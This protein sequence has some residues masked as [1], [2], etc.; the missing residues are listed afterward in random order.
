MKQV[1]RPGV[2]VLVMTVLRTPPLTRAQSAVLAVALGATGVL[3]VGV[4]AVQGG[5]EARPVRAAAA[6]PVLPLA[7]ATVGAA[8]TPDLPLARAPRWS[9]VPDVPVAAATPAAAVAPAPAVAATARTRPVLAAAPGAGAVP[10]ARR[11]ASRPVLARPAAPPALPAPSPAAG[12]TAAPADRWAFVVG[13]T[14]YAR[15]ADTIG[16]ANDAA[17]VRSQLLAAGWL[18]DHVRVVTDRAATGAAVRDGLA[19]LAARSR[20]GTFTFFHYSGHLE[21]ASLWPADGDLV[22]GSAAVRA[23]RAGTGRMWADV[24][25]CGAGAVLAGLAGDRVLV[26]ASSTGA[27]KSY[28]YPAWGRS[29]WTGLLFDLGIGHRI[30]DT[31]LD[32]RVT[33]GE[34]LAFASDHA[35]T[36]TLAQ[37]P[38]G[39]QT[40]QVSGGGSRDWTLSA[41]PA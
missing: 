21:N 2:D 30:A 36:I 25:G 15:T 37:R 32:G 6:V 8:A 17:L 23:L 9:A 19:W 35:R 33:V 7:V 29:V 12:G 40:P 4:S 22:P 27:Q 31:D 10:P 18:P 13:V 16:G 28:E 39:P 1:A 41:P 3:G 20:P 5:H 14:D 38:Y 24:A 34:A 11:P 26:S